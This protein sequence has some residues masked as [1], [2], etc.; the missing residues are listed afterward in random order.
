MA[1]RLRQRRKGGSGVA[2]ES[3]GDS[4]LPLLEAAAHAAGVPRAFDL[5][6]ELRAGGYFEETLL[7]Q[8]RQVQAALFEHA[9]EAPDPLQPALVL[10]AAPEARVRFFVPALIAD[11]HRDAPERAIE[12]LRTL[13]V[14]EDRRVAEAL[15][16]FG[17][18]PQLHLLGPAAV[19]LLR[20]WVGDLSR[21]V[22]RAAIEA[23]RPRGVWVKRMEWA[24]ANPA[25]LLP[26]LEALR[27][28]T[29]PWVA[30]AVGN[31]LNDISKDHPRL[32]L[33][34][35]SRWW[36]DADR[37][38]QV[39]RMVRKGL[40]TLLKDGDPFALRALGF[41]ALQVEATVRLENGRV[42]PPNSSLRFRLEL[43][44]RGAAADAALVYEIEMPGRNAHRPRK[45]RCSFGTVR[46]PDRGR[47]V[48]RL[49]ERIFDR[50]AAPL[51]DGPSR[52]RFL[53]NGSPVA[54]LGFEVLR[55]AATATKDVGGR[56]PGRAKRS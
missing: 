49:R 39:E 51:L 14:D 21:A 10:S 27:G 9:L 25:L 44:N 13:A 42:V 17:L 6:R 33:D 2:A 3:P 55:A 50:R 29:E 46:L 41:G 26:L 31:C 24:A 15:Q 20:P 28:E 19:A 40:R 34:V 23:S 1:G 43:R 45:Q 7:G 18:R 35:A 16:A 11:L 36:G 5:G 54:E 47:L 4:V 48:V 52:A 12:L 22:R 32:A 56:A 53:L 38:P 37:G 8:W 30:N